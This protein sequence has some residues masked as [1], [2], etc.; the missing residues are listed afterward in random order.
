MFSQH[1][2]ASTRYT[3]H[4]QCSPSLNNEFGTFVSRHYCYNIII[5]LV[6]CKVAYPHV[7]HSV[8][9]HQLTTSPIKA[10]ST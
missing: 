5:L 7:F 1:L 4:F 9:F 2:R 8:L 3:V 6:T 10:F